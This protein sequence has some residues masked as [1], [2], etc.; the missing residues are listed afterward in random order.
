MTTADF[1]ELERRKEVR[2]DL[3]DQFATAALISLANCQSLNKH[4]I[5]KDCYALADAMLAERD[6]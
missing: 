4:E 2:K 5:A 3:R 1:L 6:R